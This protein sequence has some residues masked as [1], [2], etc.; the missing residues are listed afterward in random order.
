MTSLGAESAFRGYRLQALYILHRIID[1]KDMPKLTFQPEGREDLAIY[2]GGKLVEAIQVKARGRNLSISSFSPEKPLSFFHR[3][4]KLLRTKPQPS[5]RIISFGPIGPE[6]KKAWDGDTEKQRSISKKLVAYG[7]SSSD[8]NQVFGSI[9][10]IKVDEDLV[11]NGVFAFL[12]ESLLGGDPKSA[13]ELLTYWLYL[14]SEKRDRITYSSL[15]YK[16]NRVGRYLMERAT[17]HAEW[18]TSIVPLEDSTID[19]SKLQML[20]EE[21]YQG[22]AASYEHILANVDVVRDEKLKTIN[23]L[24]QEASVVI[25]HGASGQG[26]STLA[27]RYLHDFVPD[28]WRFEIR[29]VE[30]RQHALRIARALSGHADAVDAPMIILID[31]LPS[32]RGWI[33]LVRE[34]ARHKN[35]RLLVV[36]REEDWRRASLSAAD[37]HFRQIELSF[38]ENEACHLYPH[39]SSLSPP[40]KFTDFEAAWARFGFGGPLLEFVYLVTQN[41][42]LQERL[43]AQVKNLQDSVRKGDLYPAELELLRQIAVASA[44]QARV[45]LRKL[46]DHLEL[47]APRRTLQ[48]FEKEYL[49][50]CSPDGN[51][52][53]GLHPIRSAILSGLLTDPILHPWSDV[54][55]TCLQLVDESDLEIFLLHSFSRHSDATR[56]LV[57]QLKEHQPATWSGLAGILRALLWLGVY[58]YV[59]DNKD[60]IEEA[61]DLFGSGWLF[62]LDF[63]I[64]GIGGE[65][66]E[67]WWRDLSIVPEE[68]KDK[69]AEF[70]SRQT[71]KDTV[72]QHGKMWLSDIAKAP[73]GLTTDSDWAAVAETFFWTGYLKV[74]SRVSDWIKDEDLDTAIE[75]LPLKALGDV[76]LGVSFLWDKRFSQWLAKHRRLLL[77]RYRDGTNTVMIDDDGNTIRAHFLVGF[78]LDKGYEHSDQPTSGSGIGGLHN[79]ALWRVELLRRLVPDRQ[80]Y[81][82]QGYGHRLGT[83]SLSF[84]DTEKEAIPVDSFPPPWPVQVNSWFGQLGLYPLRPS[85]WLEYSSEICELRQEVLSSLEVLRKA[86]NAHFRKQS[87]IKLTSF[88]ESSKWSDSQLAVSNPPLLPQCAS[89]EWG[90]VGES[91][92]DERDQKMPVA[93]R[94]SADK[95]PTE[96]IEIA[97]SLWQYRDYLAVLKDHTRSLSNF[98]QQCSRCSQLK[99]S[100]GKSRVPR[101]ARP[102]SADRE[103]AG[104]KH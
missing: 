40:A 22:I 10:L 43:D 53:E 83:L 90:F 54:A 13:F 2:E 11:R 65:A 23:D 47:T 57:G 89:D 24:F 46:V 68:M 67:N 98:Y 30:G 78:G 38:D 102:H 75:T 48:L 62:M 93:G 70:R 86:L 71:P 92:R 4:V 66:L 81:G 64:A 61:F 91:K 51:Y 14:A 99:H 63:D 77:E 50:R 9:G 59:A 76:V 44:Y 33:D 95:K 85:S 29:L 1:S 74:Q 5:V 79:E 39:L 45:N 104:N 31:V 82:C 15:I 8:V 87:P 17:S 26:K 6:M 34:L 88:I 96:W 20:V 7:L 94:P 84:D 58:E 56:I 3:A 37:F 100:V 12:R 19:E 35:L 25:I 80:S 28:K 49:L 60:L 103:R 16:I 27:Y 21:Y 52:V 72:F 73:T 55:R 69:I 32:F 36:I 97:F 42:T 101:G 18:F 41:E